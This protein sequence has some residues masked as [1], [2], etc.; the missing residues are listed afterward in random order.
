MNA[1]YRLASRQVKTMPLDS[2]KPAKG[3]HKTVPLVDLAFQQ[4][5]VLTSG[6]ATEGNL[7]SALSRPYNL[8]KLRKP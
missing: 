2:A 5:D 1:G 3:V 6:D 8:H 4:S 7:Y